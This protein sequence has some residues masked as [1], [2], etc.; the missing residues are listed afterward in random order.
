MSSFQCNELLVYLGC[1]LRCT[2]RK[3][4]GIILCLKIYCALETFVNA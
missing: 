2:N 1:N 4:K 3:E